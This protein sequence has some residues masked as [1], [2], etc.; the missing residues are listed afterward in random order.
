MFILVDYEN[1][2]SNGLKGIEGV[3]S[4]DKLIIFHKENS[5]MSVSAHKKMENCKAD[6]EY[7]CVN[8]ATKNAV[9]FQ[10]V[11][12]LGVLCE[13]HAD[14]EF[15]VISN[16]GGFDAAIDFLKK[17][18]IKRYKNL[19]ECKRGGKAAEG[20]VQN[21]EEVKNPAGS[22]KDSKPEEV[23]VPSTE[24]EV[25]RLAPEYSEKAQ[26]IAKVIDSYKTKQAINNNLMKIL[27]SEQVGKLH[28]KIKP[29]L[30]GKK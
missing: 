8:N 14:Q 23:S 20:G 4:K 17:Y 30:V 22:K 12:C 9:D 1:V 11:A 10:L 18:K 16:D 29:L 25:K 2:N 24:D 27:K 5:T 15:A 19:A 3:S 6:K 28:K 21:T 26:A 13:R 7:I